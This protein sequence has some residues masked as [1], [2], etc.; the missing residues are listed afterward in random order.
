MSSR[1]NKSGCPT[2]HRDVGSQDFRAPKTFLVAG[3]MSGTSADGIDVAI[4][5]V[6][7]AVATMPGAPSSATASSLPKVGSQ[8]TPRLKLLG[9]R[10][11]AYDK[12]LRNLILSIAT[13]NQ[14]T[15]RRT[16]PALLASRQPLRRLHRRHLPR[17]QPPAAASRHPRSNHLPPGHS[18]KVPRRPHPLHLADRRA[19]R[20]RRTPPHPCRQRLPPRR[21]RRR[22]TRRAA[23]P[24]A[25]LHPLP[26]RHQKSSSAQP[27]RH[28]QRHR[29][30][31]RLHLSGCSS[32]RYRPCQ[33][34][35][36]H[37][38]AT[39]LSPQ[40]RS[41]RRHRSPRPHPPR[42]YHPAAS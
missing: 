22:R 31:R 37:R 18:R 5:R 10:S 17:A 42:R 7:P 9:H 21:P 3:V 16:H 1:L 38:H 25:R 4:C 35:P 11:F 40:P 12:K 32:L 2:S 15:A 14:T 30:T 8:T 39:F 34:A 6:S 23:R 13:G 36:R 33:H 27:R 19:R 41:Q 28:R 29:A 20:H 24:H 26:P